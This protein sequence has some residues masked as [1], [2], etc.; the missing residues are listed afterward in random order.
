MTS[1]QCRLAV[2]S[3]VTLLCGCAVGPDFRRP[4]APGV[5]RYARAPTTATTASADVAGGEAQRL[6]AGQDIPGAWWT[7]FGSPALNALIERALAASPTLIAAQ[8][9]LRQAMELVA[10]QRGSFFPTVQG[11][12]SP[13]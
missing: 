4:A 7:L 11:S 10:A 8:Q 1:R 2:L 6:V 5:D 3:L 12:F 9:S 13:S